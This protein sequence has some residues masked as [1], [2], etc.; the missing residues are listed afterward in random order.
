MRDDGW[1]D[2]VLLAMALRQAVRARSQIPPELVEA[3]KNEYTWHTIDAELAELTFDSSR[4]PEAIACT[5]SESA[6]L[7]ALTFTSGRLTIDLEVTEDSLIG[8]VMPPGQGTMEAQNRD[9]A[10]VTAP[11]DE[12]GCFLFQP[13]PP[14]PFR[15]RYRNHGTDLVTGWF[16]LSSEG[17]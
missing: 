3:I 5:R 17:P 6:S 10:T 7:R 16:T 4:E 14:G 1:D 8:Q 12:I 15:L 11:V 9:G 13:I 2:D